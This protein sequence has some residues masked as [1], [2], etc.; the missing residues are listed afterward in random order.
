MMVEIHL[1]MMDP[2]RY[3][4][5]IKQLSFNCAQVSLSPDN[6]S[7]S[8]FDIL[9]SLKQAMKYRCMKVLVAICSVGPPNR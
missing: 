8:P 6:S 2:L 3:A 9:P 4:Y 5:F 1:T 7:A